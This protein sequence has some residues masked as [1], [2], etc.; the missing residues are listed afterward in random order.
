MQAQKHV[1]DSSEPRMNNNLIFIIELYK[2]K[3]TIIL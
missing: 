3:E 1:T 2:Q